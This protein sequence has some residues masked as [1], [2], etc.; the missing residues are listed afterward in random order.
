MVESKLEIPRKGW[1][2]Y[3]GLLMIFFQIFILQKWYIYKRKNMI[4]I[5]FMKY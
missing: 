5:M 2:N 4:K 1:T 3:E